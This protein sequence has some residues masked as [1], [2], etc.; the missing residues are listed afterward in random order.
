M[1]ANAYAYSAHVGDE[2]S[3][4]D[5]LRETCGMAR[6]VELI[7]D[8]WTLLILREALYGTTR[9][10]ALC[11]RL[12]CPRS[13]LSGRLR[14]LVASNIMTRRAYQEPGQRKRWQYVLT[15]K[16]IDLALPMMALMQWGEKHLLD[17]ES[18]T[19][20]TERRTGAPVRVSLVNDRDRPIAVG[21]ASV[22]AP[23]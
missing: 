22:R 1:M 13:I 11:E 6:A 15:S 17:A 23:T 5:S 7:G 2:E 3:S 20:L 21:D 14:K 9:F 19:Q 16:G 8:R 4:P 18:E 12:G 10:D